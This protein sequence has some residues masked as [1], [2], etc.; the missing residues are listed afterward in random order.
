MI[1]IPK[2]NK[3]ERIN[4]HLTPS[5]KKRIKDMADEFHMSMSS[6]I[7]CASIFCNITVIG[8]ETSFKNILTELNR[9]GSNINQLRMLSQLGR[10]NVVSLEE[11]VD[12]LDKIKKALK[13]ILNEK[14][15]WQ[16]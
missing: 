12:E 1:S 6:Y 13:K 16:H 14:T 9:I 11:T 4:L 7:T 10:I 5:D 15:K 8:D 2:E 3:T